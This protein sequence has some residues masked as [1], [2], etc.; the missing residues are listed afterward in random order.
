MLRRVECN[1]HE[2]LRRNALDGRDVLAADHVLAAET[3]QDF[4]GGFGRERF[5]TFRVGDLAEVDDEKVGGRDCALEPVPAKAL[6]A[7]AAASA[8]ANF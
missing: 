3:N 2:P 4:R 6:S 1:D 8:I 5:E 7:T